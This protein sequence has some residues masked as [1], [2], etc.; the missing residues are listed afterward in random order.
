M[1]IKNIDFLKNVNS[2]H[3]NLVNPDGYVN[4]RNTP[5]VC[6]KW[7]FKHACHSVGQLFDVCYFLTT[8]RRPFQMDA[9]FVRFILID[10]DHYKYVVYK[11]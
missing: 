7:L 9:I 1:E 10:P 2:I 3:I 5:S 11:I 8:R 4:V 6:S